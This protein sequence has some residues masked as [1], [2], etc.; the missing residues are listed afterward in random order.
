M[1]NIVVVGGLPHPIGGVTTF[2]S[3]LIK[4]EKSVGVLFD[5]YPSAHK[6]LPEKYC[7]SYIYSSIKV[8]TVLRLFLY[9][10]MRKNLN[11]HFNFSTPRS[12]ALLRWLP[13]KKSKW[14]LTLHHGNLGKMEPWMARVLSR[15][16]DVFLPL[17]TIQR[18]WYSHVETKKIVNSSSYLPAGEPK[19]NRDLQAEIIK[20]RSK[21]DQIIICSGYP[22]DIYNHED[23]FELM[24]LRPKDLLI[25][26]LYG[27]GD[28]RDK[29]TKLSYGKN[30]IIKESFDEDSFNYLLKSSDLYLRLNSED[31]FGIAVADAVNYGIRVIATNVCARYPG[32]IIVPVGQSVTELNEVVQRT[33]DSPLM[34]R[35]DIGMPKFEYSRIFE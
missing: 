25:C 10:A 11:V 3:R 26:C 31:S 18:Q 35:L 33:I 22:T 5:L 27:P 7:G 32:A 23:A 34:E 4:S 12:L 6:E 17:N 28:L 29:L 21:Y 1:K 19:C 14:A 13:K 30:I 2:I 24:A 20:Y 16:V 9:V 8:I 15:K